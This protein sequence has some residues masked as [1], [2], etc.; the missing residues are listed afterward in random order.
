MEALQI[1]NEDVTKNFDFF[2]FFSK[3]S[4]ASVTGGAD[5]GKL[6]QRE[7]LLVLRQEKWGQ[8]LGVWV[9]TGQSG[10]EKKMP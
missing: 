10:P 4:K 8:R 3:N 2:G 7:R 9:L 1:R 6:K 5:V